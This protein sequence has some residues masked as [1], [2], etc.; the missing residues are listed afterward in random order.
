M[1]PTCG[2][3][4]WP[5]ATCQ[6]S[7]R[8]PAIW[9]LVSPSAAIW[10]GTV[11]CCA[12]LIS[13]LPP[14]ATTRVSAPC[15]APSSVVGD[16]LPSAHREGHDRLLGMEPV[17]GLVVDDRVGTVDDGV[18]DL[19]VPVGRQRVHVDG[20]VGRAAPSAARR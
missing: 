16:G 8:S 18:G 17:L 12:S 13:E 9:T 5:I 3:L 20:V 4:P 2:P 19:D 7:R 10:S 1:N 11:W 6:P 14:I 15:L